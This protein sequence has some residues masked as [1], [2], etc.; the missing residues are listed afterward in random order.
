MWN[1]SGCRAQSRGE[2]GLVIDRLTGA[3]AVAL[4]AA[5]VLPTVAAFA[6]A[7]AP[8]LVMALVV[9]LFARLLM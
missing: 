8:A 2:G 9:L 5:I 1:Q 3:V 6:E 7:V 4:A